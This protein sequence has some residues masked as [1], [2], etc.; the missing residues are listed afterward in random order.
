MYCVYGCA[1]ICACVHMQIPKCYCQPY[2]DLRQV[3]PMLIFRCKSMFLDVERGLKK[4]QWS[5]TS[6]HEQDM[7][8]HT[9]LDM[10]L[11]SLDILAKGF[12]S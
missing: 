1:W 7:K 12:I 10:Q 6:G 2:L 9:A 5:S 8:I 11:R 4:K 3:H